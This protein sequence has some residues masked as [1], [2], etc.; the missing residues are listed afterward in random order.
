[1]C[2]SNLLNTYQTLDPRVQQLCRLV[3]LWGKNKGVIDTKSGYLGSYAFNL[4]A[5][6]YLQRVV[7]PPILP[8]LQK[9][10]REVRMPRVMKTV[11]RTIKKER[12]K[13]SSD[14]SFV[15]DPNL[16]RKHMSEHYGKNNSSI[17]ELLKGFF[18][19][20]ANDY[21]EVPV[22]NGTISIKEGDFV[23]STLQEQD[24]FISLQEPFDVKFNVGCRI[25]WTYA[26][27]QVKAEFTL[28][29]MKNTLKLLEDGD[30]E[31]A[32]RFQQFGTIVM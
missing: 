32:F 12:E 9:L 6:F 19:F 10:A 30:L 24:Y 11:E 21:H 23:S 15:S 25:N 2:G 27:C 17:L 31:A 5:I 1:V 4:M 13:F 28:E 29:Q 16:L 14:V 8:S 20:Y 7:N 22:T 18:N 3:K 26:D